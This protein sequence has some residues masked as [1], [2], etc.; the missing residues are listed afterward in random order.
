MQTAT[1]KIWG[2]SAAVDQINARNE[3]STLQIR[4]DITPNKTK[5][6][7]RP[8]FLPDDSGL[9][10]S[11]TFTEWRSLLL[12]VE[13]DVAFVKRNARYAGRTTGC[14]QVRT[15]NRVVKWKK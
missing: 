4:L 7:K 10:R 6:I 3:H 15:T 9:Q 14:I 11:A 13:S 12:T 2:L 8:P 5:G 1:V